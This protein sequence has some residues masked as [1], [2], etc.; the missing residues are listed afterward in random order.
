[1]LKDITLGQYFP[2]DSKLHKLDSRTKILLLILDIVA[3]FMAQSFYSYCLIILF[4]LFIVK[5]SK[6]PVNTL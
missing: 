3:I 1:M 6:V 5:I 4:T 2:I